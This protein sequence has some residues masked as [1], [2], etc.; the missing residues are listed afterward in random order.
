M[1]DTAVRYQGR[2][3]TQD[4][5]FPGY[6]WTIM[7]CSRCFG[8]LGWK[9]T[10]VGVDQDEEAN[11]SLMSEDDDDDDD[12]M[13]QLGDDDDHGMDDDYVTI[14]DEDENEA[15]AETVEE[16]IA[17]NVDVENSSSR[18]FFSANSATSAPAANLIQTQPLECN[19]SAAE[20]SESEGEGNS[21]SQT[22]LQEFWYVL[23]HQS[24]WIA[25][26]ISIFHFV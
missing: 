2:P 21:I 4:T 26:V 22:V 24:C 10:W 1:A 15:D 13:L 23:Y 6:A 16:A 25:D 18:S 3:S 9:Y 8:H 20:T 11:S 19:R 12:D 14:D 5:W 7:C 17:N